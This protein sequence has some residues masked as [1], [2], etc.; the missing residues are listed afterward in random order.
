MRSRSVSVRDA[1]ETPEVAGGSGFGC[2]IISVFSG[3]VSVAGGCLASG[4][5][6]TF[7][8]SVFGASAFGASLFGDSVFDGSV[9]AG[10]VVATVG[11]AGF[12][13]VLMPQTLAPSAGTSRAT[14]RISGIGSRLG[15]VGIVD[16][17][18]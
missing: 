17:S 8:G 5:G 15:G 6:S 7:T 16:T 12:M 3:L 13:N 4:C 10:S 18:D 1:M 9:L 11:S 14:L 2:G